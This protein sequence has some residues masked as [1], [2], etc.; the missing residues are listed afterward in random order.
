MRLKHIFYSKKVIFFT[1]FVF[2]IFYT[3]SGYLYLRNKFEY[4]CFINSAIKSQN[5]LALL[6]ENLT[7]NAI[8]LQV[9]NLRGFI[10]YVGKNEIKFSAN[11]L[12]CEYFKD[13]DKTK[14]L[15]NKYTI[16]PEDVNASSL[17][18]K[19]YYKHQNFFNKGVSLIREQ[20]SLFNGKVQM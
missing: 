3:L 18:T 2:F 1:I 4:R 7:K 8:A 11:S 17:D 10:V 15:V 14:N 12:V 5:I 20:C 19:L 9:V 6:D 13:I 16:M